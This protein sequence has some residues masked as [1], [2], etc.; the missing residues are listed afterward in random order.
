MSKQEEWLDVQV[1][2]SRVVE[3][4][5]WAAKFWYPS[6]EKEGPATALAFVAAVDDEGHFS[7]QSGQVL[8]HVGN[9]GSGQESQ[10]SAAGRRGETKNAT[11]VGFDVLAQLL[12]HSA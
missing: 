5:A 3:M 4:P 2:V 1:E 6:V 9:G 10:E 12:K 8:E 11:H 7:R